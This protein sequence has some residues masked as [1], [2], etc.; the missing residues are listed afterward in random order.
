MPSLN[1]FFSQPYYISSFGHHHIAYQVLARLALILSRLI[2]LTSTTRIKPTRSLLT[3]TEQIRARSPAYSQSTPRSFMQ[4]EPSKAFQNHLSQHVAPESS[5]TSQHGLRED[6]Q[7][8]LLPHY[9]EEPREH[10][11]DGGVRRGSMRGSSLDGDDADEAARLSPTSPSPRDRITEYENALT[12]SAKKRTEGLAFEV[13]KS[14]KKPDDRSCA[15]ANLPN[16]KCI[17]L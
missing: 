12:Q 2:T 7:P 5:T 16:G 1:P 13:I 11:P 3:T 10:A 9:H 6:D 14:A 17:L 4:P 8:S 15:I